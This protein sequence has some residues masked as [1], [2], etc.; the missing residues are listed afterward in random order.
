M[1]HAL[2]VIWDGIVFLAVLPIGL[3]FF[4]LVGLTL[5]MQRIRNRGGLSL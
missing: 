1:R 3:V 5:W 4:S 2:R